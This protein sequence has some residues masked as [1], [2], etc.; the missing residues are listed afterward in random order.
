MWS[1]SGMARTVTCPAL[2]ARVSL[3]RGEG[4]GVPTYKLG[5]L[6]QLFPDSD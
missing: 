6:W 2:G 1:F 4:G 5:C 3:K